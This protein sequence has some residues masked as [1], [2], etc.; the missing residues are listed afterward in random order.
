VVEKPMALS[1]GDCDRMIEAARAHDVMLVVGHSH[2]FDPAVAAIRALVRDDVYGPLGMISTWDYTDF[3]YR[4]RRPEELDPAA[5]GGILFNQLPHQVD[6]VRTIADRPVL[7]VTARTAV[8]DPER[9]VAG[10]CAATLDLA[11]STV[12]TIV[13]SGYDHFDSDELHGWVAEGGG[14]KRPAHGSSRAML[15]GL[16]PLAEQAA[17]TGRFGYGTRPSV[18]PVHQPH[19]GELVVSCAGA[20]LRPGPDA[21]LAYTDDGVR[22]HPLPQARWWPGRGDVIEELVQAVARRSPA[23]HDGAFGRETLRVCLAAER[24]AADRVAVNLASEV[25]I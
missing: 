9:R 25:P 19:F 10:A 23:L 20:D 7:S 14:D 21:V 18:R 15:R 4:P 13:Y 24:S 22:E 1:T 2:G 12:A 3:L 8:L 11:G 6:V 5:G 16:T 17:R